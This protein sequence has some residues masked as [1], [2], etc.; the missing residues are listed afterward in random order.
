MGSLKQIVKPKGTKDLYGK[1][2][3]IWQK[4]EKEIRDITQNRNVNEIRTP[5]FEDTA[6]FLR[7]V[8][9]E[10]DIVNK[11][12]YTFVDKGDRSITLRP[13]LTAC[14]VRSY[15]ENG[16]SSMT[17][18]LKF[19][20]I[21]NMYR[22]EKMQKG[23]FREFSQFGVEIF[24]SN[25]ILVEVEA[26]SIAHELFKR[27]DLLD[28]IVLKIN[29][30]G[31]S[32][33][34]AAYIETMKSYLSNKIDNMCDNCK[35]RYNKNPMRIIDCKEEYC[36][37]INKNIPMITDYLCEDCNNDFEKLKD[38]LNKI[39]IN[40]E[41]DKTIV[42]GLDYYNGSVFEFESKDLKLAVGGGGRY[43]TIIEK[44]GGI[45]TPAIGFALGMDRIQILLE[46]LNI[47]NSIDIY[48]AV[49]NNEIFKNTF[50]IVNKLRNN[51][52]K[53]DIDICNRSFNAQLKYANKLNASYV[54]IIGDDEIKNGE[55]VIKDMK[56]GNQEKIKLDEKEILEYIKH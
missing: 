34:R 37:N 25:S 13:E 5:V 41:I 20:Y 4:I 23:R 35:I 8:G 15:I 14:I 19:W 55:C 17:S 18:P 40:Y 44:L 2:I 31:C 38:I 27:L 32:K 1:E 36:K 53:C 12:M 46:S 22:Y 49:M 50:N 42:R 26:I 24:G 30:I 21:G 11:E 10:T 16:F 33:C 48:F 56:S 43:D 28:K 6:L 7:G 45:K 29:S 47:E 54:V 9:D 39:G 51:S 52:I 3:K